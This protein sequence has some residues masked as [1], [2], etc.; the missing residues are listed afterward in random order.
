MTTTDD[1]STTGPM[2]ETDRLR[3]AGFS[4][5]YGV[6]SSSCWDRPDGVTIR[7]V[8]PDLFRIQPFDRA[9]GPGRLLRGT[10]AD[11]IAAAEPEIAICGRYGRPSADGVGGWYHEHVWHDGPSA[12]HAV[13][14]E[15]ALVRIPPVHPGSPHPALAVGQTVPARIQRGFPGSGLYDHAVVEVIADRGRT[16]MFAGYIARPS[17]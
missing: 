15:G 4:P 3:R 13:S 11:A 16:G 1:T 6:E 8:S 17:R 9:D 14:H 2:A 7:K 5:R 12:V 10:L